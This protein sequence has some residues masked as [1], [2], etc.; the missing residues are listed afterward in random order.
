VERY[1]NYKGYS[2]SFEWMGN[3]EDLTPSDES[4]RKCCTLVAIDAI[5]FHETH[6][7]FKPHNVER[8]LNKA[9]AG[10]LGPKNQRNLMP[11]ATGNWGCGAFGVSITVLFT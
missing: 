10:F 6:H 9:F 2:S 3:Y 7:Q 8:E 1:N 5:H 4:R 11:V